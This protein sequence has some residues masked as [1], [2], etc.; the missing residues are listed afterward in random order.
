MIMFIESEI[1]KNNMTCTKSISD[2]S[3]NEYVK[4]FKT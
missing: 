4:I 2:V 3:F 1:K